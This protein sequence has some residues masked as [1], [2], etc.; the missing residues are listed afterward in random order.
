[1]F[2]FDACIWG[3]EVPIRFGMI[4]VAVLFPGGDFVDE[5]L[6]VRNAAVPTSTSPTA[7]GLG[8][9]WLIGSEALQFRREGDGAFLIHWIT[10]LVA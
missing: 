3:R 1:V 2:E 5:R 10:F 9:K 7:S 8:C 6:F 4:G